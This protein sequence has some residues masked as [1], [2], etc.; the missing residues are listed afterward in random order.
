MLHFICTML[1][2]ILHNVCPSSWGLLP[3]GLHHTHENVPYSVLPQAIVYAVPSS[4][5]TLC[6]VN[7]YLPFHITTHNHRRWEAFLDLHLESVTPPPL[8]ALWQRAAQSF[9]MLPLQRYACF[10]DYTWLVSVKVLGPI[11]AR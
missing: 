4:R 11:F 6:L 7:S 8:K 10:C 1:P 2:F 5:I 9:Y 3:T